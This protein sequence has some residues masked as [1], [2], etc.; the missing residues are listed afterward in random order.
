MEQVLFQWWAA[1]RTG[2]AAFPRQEERRRHGDRRREI[3]SR[4][5][6]KEVR[7]IVVRVRGGGITLD[8]RALC[9]VRAR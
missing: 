6:R 5:D 4:L 8:D 1:A 2:S 9:H 3:L 7:K